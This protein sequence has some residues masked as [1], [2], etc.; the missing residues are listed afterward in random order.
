MVSSASEKPVSQ[1][2]NTAGDMIHLAQRGAKRLEMFANA[3]HIDTGAQAEVA[4]IRRLVDCH[5]DLIVALRAI[6]SFDY[7]KHPTQSNE[8]AEADYF[9]EC[10][11]I[12]KNA[13]ARIAPVLETEKFFFHTQ[14]CSI[15]MTPGLVKTSE[16][17]VAAKNRM[18]ALGAMNTLNKHPADEMACRTAYNLAVADFIDA[19]DEMTREIAAARP[20][21][22]VSPEPLDNSNVADEK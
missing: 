12:A 15:P 8:W 14:T 10:Q 1:G 18:D 4:A 5:D 2:E 13:L 20:A 22:S 11:A 6:A 19:S 21:P 3:I 7:E 9:N 17:Y 16:K